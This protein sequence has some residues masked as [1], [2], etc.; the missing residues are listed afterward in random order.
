[1]T[2]GISGLVKPL[3]KTNYF[4]PNL[5][6]LRALNYKTDQTSLQIIITQQYYADINS[7]YDS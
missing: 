3:K 6:I 5:L 2:I 1:M 7:I 4:N